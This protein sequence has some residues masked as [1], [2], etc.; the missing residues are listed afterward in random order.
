M[1]NEELI[2]FAKI[3]GQQTDF[4]EVLR[5]VAHKATQFLKADLALILML[6]PDTRETVK[7]I[8]KDGKH[9]E[10]REYQDIHIHIGGWIVNHSKPF[11]SRNI[12]KDDRFVK[13]LFDKVPLKS[14]SGVPLII[15]GI[16]I[17]AL[18]LL[19]RNPQDCADQDLL[20][21]LENIASISAPFLRNVQKIRSF[22]DSTLP[23]ASLVLKYEN[24]GL[25]GKSSK[26]I[27]LLHAIEAATKCDV[28]VILD[29]KTGTGKELIARAIH[30]FSS[31]TNFPFIAV[32]CGA[33]P[34]TLLESELFGHKRGAFT[35][36]HTDRQGLLLD[37]NR[38][39]LFMDEINNL[40]YDMQSKLLRV[41]EE[42]EVRPLGGDTVVETDVRIITASSV[43]LKSLVEDHLFREDL[44]FRL[45]VFPI[46]VPDLSERQADIALLANHFLHHY[47]RQQNKN[48]QNFHEEVID[49]VKQRI[50]RG[51]IRELENFVER[52]VTLTANDVSVIDGE[53][54]PEDLKEELLVFREKSK[55]RYQMESLKTSVEE[56]ETQLLTQTL[57]E[58]QWNQ[59]EA[60]RRLKT[61]EKNIRYKMKKL[62]IQKPAA[63]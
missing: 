21:Y 25:Y 16:I 28:R 51:N 27:E 45:H 1:Q 52:L 26:F 30:R 37:A 14:V 44:F 38:G 29:G 18:I 11:L 12:Q 41:L 15:E 61:S 2:E 3:L 49:F 33:I 35:G 48:A 4:Q 19:Y 62:K 31:R 13:G 39:T 43:P 9:I 63:D 54:F 32:D 42:G 46:Y 36:A 22:F 6:N 59:S 23:E 50:W 60:A 20:K 56:Y 40:P 58:C 24:A 7:T 47:T 10:Q 55:S 57:M 8:M 5:L 53:S 17:G 34:H